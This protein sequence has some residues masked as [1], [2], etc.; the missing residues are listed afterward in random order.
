MTKSYY[1]THAHSHY[2][3][4]DGLSS[5]EDMCKTV[6]GLELPGFALTDHGN[7][8]GSVQ[9]LQEAKKASIKPTIGLEAYVSA[10]Q[11]TE[12]SAI[13]RRHS[14]LLI[15]AKNTQGWI[16]LLKLFAKSN[17]PEHY[18]Y[19]PRLSLDEIYE[20][21]DGNLMFA[22][23]HYGSVLSDEL[24]GHEGKVTDDRLEF[25]TNL[26][27]LF[28][29]N[30]GADNLFLEAQL[31]DKE[32][33]PMTKVLTDAIRKIGQQTNTR[34]VACPD[35]HYCT[36]EDAELQ[37]ILL[38][39]NMGGKTLEEAQAAGVLS[40]FFQSQ[41]YHLPSY[42][43]MVD[44]GHTEEEL[45]NT[46]AFQA[47]VEE[48]EILKDPVLPEFETPDKSS[49]ADYLTNLCRQGWLKKIKDRID[50]E[51]HGE[52]AE[53]VKYELGVL[54]GAKLDSYFL[55]VQDIIRYAESKGYLV[56][57]GRGSA[58]GCLVSYLIGITKVDP[59]KYDLIFERFYNSSRKGSLPDI[60]MDF[61]GH[62]RDDIVE[63]LKVKYGREYV[64]QMATYGTLSGRSALKDTMRAQGDSAYIMDEI[65][66]HI[67]EPAKVAGE[68]KE[69]K[70]ETGSDSLILFAL[71]NK[72]KQFKE[73]CTLKDGKLTGPYAKRFEQAMKL[74]G[75]VVTQSKHAAGLIISPSIL[76]ETCPLIYDKKAKV[77]IAGLSMNDLESIGCVKLD[78][79]GV[80]MLSKMM[81]LC[82]ILA[83]KE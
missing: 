65:T 63:Y 8:A 51:K 3:L 73:W 50:A 57:P 60:D 75:T 66:K 40:T 67:P 35:A 38:C 47:Q 13:N 45:Q 80:N 56:G 32:I 79:L 34:V 48:Y 55:I 20:Y 6:S 9:L 43:E 15:Y 23:G 17:S 30:V 1:I 77:H 83:G 53:R 72:P 39:R 82:D 44:A 69:Q 37:R 12:K 21:A 28:K 46:L 61:P 41:N 25:A 26:V 71:E 52:Y 10:H 16:Q 31:I 49:P 78:I 42:Q 81:T 5:P 4:L 7:L 62:T 2:S 27:K 54:Q 18:Y 68:L 58:A 74:E 24:L 14:H 76:D 19:R 59:I 22:M 33:V 36:H 11:S 70:D 29:D 64:C